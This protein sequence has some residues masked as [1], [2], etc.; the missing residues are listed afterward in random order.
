MA[1]FS[2]QWLVLFVPPVSHH[3]IF[4]PCNFC[5]CK[6]SAS[7]LS[8]S[9]QC[10]N[11]DVGM[12]LSYR[13]GF[14]LLTIDAQ[15]DKIVLKSLICIGWSC[16]GLTFFIGVQLQGQME[17]YSLWHNH[18]KSGNPFAYLINPPLVQSTKVSTSLSPPHDASFLFI[19]Y[20]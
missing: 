12:K 16:N 2:M 9:K 5:A 7:S 1:P 13:S 10:S 18:R 17:M 20:P 15:I 6:M 14:E 3:M 4:F 11:H 19:Q 8:I